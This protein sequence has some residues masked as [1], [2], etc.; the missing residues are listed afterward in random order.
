LLQG[1]REASSLTKA[2]FVSLLAALH[3]KGGKMALTRLTSAHVVL[4][5]PDLAQT[6]FTKPAHGPAIPGSAIVAKAVATSPP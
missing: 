4:L 3:A 6:A 5:S 2:Y 1:L